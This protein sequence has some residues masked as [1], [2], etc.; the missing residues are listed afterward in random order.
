MIKQQNG[1]LCHE[2]LNAQSVGELSF[3]GAGEFSAWKKA[4]HEK[5]Y[6]LLGMARIAENACEGK[7]ELEEDLVMDGYRRIRFTV[8]TERDCTIP[9]YLLIPTVGEGPFPVAVTLQGHTTGFHNSIGVIK[10][11]KDETYQPRASFA[12]QAVAHGFAALCIELRGMGELRSPL[13]PRGAHP[14][15]FTALT[16]LNL[17][18]T[19][20]GERVWDI[21]RVIDVLGQFEGLDTEKIMITGNSGGGTATFYAGCM[22]ERISLCVPSCSFCSYR[23]SI[24]SIVHCVCNNIPQASRYFE[25][26]DLSALIAPRRL[27]VVTGVEDDIFPIA[28]VR[29]SYRT[30]ERIYKTAG[31]P[32]NCRLVETPKGHWWCEDLVWGSVEE[33]VKEMGWR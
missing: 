8:E 29:D 28:G 7:V 19:V 20:I 1:D 18:R 14:C 3:T 13:Y 21:S 9:C 11:E 32:A 23:A 16:A 31:V 24:M 17:G 10:Y 27:T 26:E 6:E 15:C 25:M 30:V 5:L 4:L 2:K 33:T 22:D 12:L